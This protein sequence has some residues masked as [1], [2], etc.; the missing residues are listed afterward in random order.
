MICKW[1]KK[2]IL[3]GESSF[4]PKERPGNPFAALHVSKSLSEI[5]RLRLTVAKLEI[6][7]ERLKN[8]MGYSYEEHKRCVDNYVD[9]IKEVE[10]ENENI[11]KV[12]INKRKEVLNDYDKSAKAGMP[13]GGIIG[14]IDLLETIMEEI[15]I[16]DEDE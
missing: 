3:E 10:K 7:N 14:E 8:V 16:G 13:T 5:D 1:V 11:K 9:K 6:E 12:L 2:Y 4:E 15:G